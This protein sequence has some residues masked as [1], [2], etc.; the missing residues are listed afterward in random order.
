VSNGLAPRSADAP[1]D[2]SAVGHIVG[3]L[4]ARARTPLRRLYFERIGDVHGLRPVEFTVLMLAWT[5]KDVTLKRLTQTLSVTAPNITVVIDRLEA[6]GLVKRIRSQADRR[7]MMIH[8]QP[9]GERIAREAGEISRTMEDPALAMLSPA[10]R[11]SL[12]AMLMRV[13]EGSR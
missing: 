5:N 2:E 3:Y 9:A 8:V 4:V 13:I 11:R 1:L 6:R 12:V 7:S 10:E